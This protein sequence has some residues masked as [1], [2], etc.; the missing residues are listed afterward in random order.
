MAT[1]LV[2]S[3]AADDDWRAYTLTAI[4]AATFIFTMTNPLIVVFAAG[5]LGCFGI[6]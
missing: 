6:V 2:M 3:R 1:S 4:C 5:V